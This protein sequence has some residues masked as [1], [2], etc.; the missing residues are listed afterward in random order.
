MGYSKYF[1]N[2]KS[3]PLLF[4]HFRTQWGPFLVLFDAVVRKGLT[5]CSSPCF[6]CNVVVHSGRHAVAVVASDSSRPS[7]CTGV[8]WLSSQDSENICHSSCHFPLWSERQVKVL[9]ARLMTWYT[10][11]PPATVLINRQMEQEPRQIEQ[12]FAS[13]GPARLFK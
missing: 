11:V 13:V 9:P 10:W 2:T 1:E 3:F 8:P 6:R 12:C 4:P 5:P 7:D